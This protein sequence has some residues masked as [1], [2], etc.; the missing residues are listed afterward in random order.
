MN[1]NIIYTCIP[2]QPGVF[3]CIDITLLGLSSDILSSLLLHLSKENSFFFFF[4]LPRA[5]I[6]HII[7]VAENSHVVVFALG[8]V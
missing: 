4:Y 8:L 2:A 1:R 6:V 7:R 5:A 3:Y